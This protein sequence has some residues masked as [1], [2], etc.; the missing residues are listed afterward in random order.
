MRGGTAWGLADQLAKMTGRRVFMVCTA[1]GGQPISQWQPGVGAVGLELDMQ[2]SDALAA[3]QIDY[4]QVKFA[5]IVV[6]I[7]G[8]RDAQKN[9]PPD[10][11][12]DH[13]ILWRDYVEG[14][15]NPNPWVDSQRTRWYLV[16]MSQESRRQ[17]AWPGQK[18]TLEKAGGRTVLI[19]SSGKE[20][21]E[22]IH[23]WGDQ[24][25]L[26]GEEIAADVVSTTGH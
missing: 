19:P 23:Y 25:T 11:Y 17:A 8:E 24:A 10:L 20:T 26:F 18:Y 4:P 12:A 22:G 7:Q 2:V 21:I 15:N 5:D 1:Q 14:A 9:T 6:W 13:W 16:Q 3:L